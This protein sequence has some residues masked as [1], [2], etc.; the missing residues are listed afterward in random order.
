[1]P[2]RV[3]QWLYASIVDA[4]AHVEGE[5]TQPFSS[6]LPATDSRL[7]VR[8]AEV[9][10]LLRQGL[11]NHQIGDR[12]GVSINTVKKHV[13]SAYEKRGIRSRRQTLE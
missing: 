12:L 2:R 8:E 5:S 1:L 13:A 7:T 6:S 11:T 3:M 4:P 9:V 10:S